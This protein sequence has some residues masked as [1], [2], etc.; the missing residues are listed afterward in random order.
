MLYVYKTYDEP[1]HDDH[2]YVTSDYELHVTYVMAMCEWLTCLYEE[3]ISFKPFSFL[4][5]GGSYEANPII[6]YEM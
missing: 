1:N 4:N 6:E 3:V 5:G 2:W